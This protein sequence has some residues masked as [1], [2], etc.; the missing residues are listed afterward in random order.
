MGAP[1]DGIEIDVDALRRAADLL[2]ETAGPLDALAA[3]MGRALGDAAAA[4][5]AP[6]LNGALA[7][8]RTRW[9]AAVSA[10]AGRIMESGALLRDGVELHVA[11][12]EGGGF[13]GPA[14]PSR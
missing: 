11:T 1:G 8:L 14:R 12:D 9:E 3:Q 13:G 5:G 7:D 10:A 4:A 6:A 2:T